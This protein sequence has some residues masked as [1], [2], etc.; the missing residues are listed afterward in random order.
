MFWG[1]PL[2]RSRLQDHD[3]G[4]GQD[5]I[6]PRSFQ[7]EPESAENE[8]IAQAG[9]FRPTIPVVVR[10]CTGEH[11]A[12]GHAEARAAVGPTGFTTRY[13]AALSMRGRHIP[14]QLLTD[15]SYELVLST[16]HALA[17]HFYASPYTS[18]EQPVFLFIPS[19]T[20]RT[21]GSTD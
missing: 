5:L 2:E 7:D 12:D 9:G 16:G 21:D 11:F 17:G 14:G 1:R 4:T 10:R 3:V 8:H 6:I 18:A 15:D 20:D 13:L 19:A